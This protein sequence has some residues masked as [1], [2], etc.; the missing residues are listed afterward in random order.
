MELGKQELFKLFDQFERGTKAESD[1]FITYRSVLHGVMTK[2]E[3]HFNLSLSRN[4]IESLADSIKKW[5]LF[6]DTNQ[7]LRKL[8]EKYDLVVV[9]NIDE[10]L[11]NQTAQNF[12]VPIDDT[13]LADQVRSYKP[14]LKHFEVALEKLET[15]P[16]TILHVA[17]SVYHD[18]K[19]ATELGWDTVW[20]RRYG[21]RMG[22]P[23]PK[24]KPSLVVDDL[25]SLVAVLHK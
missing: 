22:S 20:V 11:F 14:S 10:D 4:E 1:Q 2:F 17:Q 8:R 6:Q 16:A 9:S 24:C 21:G 12:S 19:P 25:Q 13:V 7:A 23:P 3:D 15:T 5:P 18:I